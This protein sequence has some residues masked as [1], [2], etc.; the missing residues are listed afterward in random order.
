MLIFTGES[1]PISIER[2]PGIEN[3]EITASPTGWITN[4][5][6]L[7]WFKKFSSSPETKKLV[8][9]DGHATNLQEE[10]IEEALKLNIIVYCLPAHTSQ[11]IQPLDMLFNKELKKNIGIT[12]QKMKDRN[13]YNF[14]SIISEAWQL[15]TTFT[16]ITSSFQMSGIYPPSVSPLKKHFCGTDLEIIEQICKEKRN[17]TSKKELFL[18][19]QIAPQIQITNCNS[20]NLLIEPVGSTPASQSPPETPNLIVS[21]VQKEQNN[22]LVTSLIQSPSSNP[23]L[24]VSPS[25]CERTL[26]TPNSTIQYSPTSPNITISPSQNPI[27][28]TEVIQTLIPTSQ[29]ITPT[30]NA[31]VANSLQVTTIN[32]KNV[33]SSSRRKGFRINTSNGRILNAEVLKEKRR[34]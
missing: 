34:A 17:G 21:S 25:Q 15:T 33:A 31:F 8:I 3:V 27:I 5:I 11:L 13:K 18:N 19:E 24:I 1:I 30:I 9:L 22:S 23:N 6:K 4:E 16:T 14:I 20:G 2:L 26:I 7:Q 32:N 28:S 29:M 10:L 12:S